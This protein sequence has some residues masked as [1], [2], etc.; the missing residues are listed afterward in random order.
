MVFF[1]L[2][3][4][5]FT[6]SNAIKVHPCCQKRQDFLFIWL[7]IYSVYLSHKKKSSISRSHSVV[8]NSLRP[9][10]L[11]SPWNYP[12]QNKW[13]GQPFPSPG[14]LPNPRIEPRSSAL[15]EDALSDEPQ[16][17]P[18]HIYMYVYYTILYLFIHWGHLGCLHVIDVA[19][20]TSMIHI[21]SF[22]LCSSHTQEHIHP[23]T[24][25]NQAFLPHVDQVLLFSVILV[26]TAE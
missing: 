20:N 10:R 23:V 16:G 8:S 6:Q 14:D 2:C 18:I 26:W 4:A 24:F 12:G 22:S 19:N 7:N 3:M 25:C 1:F 5:Y 13:S 17:K 21:S 11:Y 9:H 15:Q